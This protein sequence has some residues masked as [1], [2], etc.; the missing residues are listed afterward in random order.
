MLKS[1]YILDTNSAWLSP[2]TMYPFVERKPETC[3]LLFKRIPGFRADN[4]G[5]YMDVWLPEASNDR[6]LPVAM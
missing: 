4:D 5:L 1:R 2:S 3:R 6:A